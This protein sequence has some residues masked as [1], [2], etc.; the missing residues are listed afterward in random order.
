MDERRR[1]PRASCVLPA[2]L[3]R[4]GDASGVPILEMS[5]SGL[6][7][8]TDAPVKM[9]QMLELEVELPDRI[10]KMF[11]TVRSAGQ[12]VRGRGIGAEIFVIDPADRTAWVQQYYR[13]LERMS[14]DQDA[15][16]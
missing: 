5:P 12:T 16:L 8:L 6:F 10:I 1:A 4:N 2:R 9:R 13:E 15:T 3:L 14:R 11:V 7:L